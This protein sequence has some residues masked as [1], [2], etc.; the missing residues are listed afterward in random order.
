MSKFA[1]VYCGEVTYAN[2]GGTPLLSKIPIKHLFTKVSDRVM[3]D[4]FKPITSFIR[5]GCVTCGH[6]VLIPRL[7]T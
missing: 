6:S 5:C 1:H 3:Q 4:C 7:E 2:I